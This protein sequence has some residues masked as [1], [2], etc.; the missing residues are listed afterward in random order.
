[1]ASSTV[2]FVRAGTGGHLRDYSWTEGMAELEPDSRQQGKGAEDNVS[3]AWSLPS[4]RTEDDISDDSEG[5]D[6][7]LFRMGS[8]ECL[9]LFAQNNLT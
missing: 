9:A 7:E 8:S 5:V 1:L 6:N 3:E 2:R 4:V